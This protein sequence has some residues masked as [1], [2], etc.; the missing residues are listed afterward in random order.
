MEQIIGIVDSG[1][2]FDYA[3]KHDESVK[4]G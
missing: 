3:V 4:G 1:V 2:K